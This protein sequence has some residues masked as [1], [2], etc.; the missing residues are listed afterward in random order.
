MAEQGLRRAAFIDRD[1]VINRELH[2][3]HR[4][5]DFHV[6]PG[7]VEGLRMLAA[8]GY[9]LVVVTNQGGIAKGLYTPEQYESLTAHMRQW[10]QA[11][12]VEFDGIYHCPHHPGGTV[13][14]WSVACTC[15]KPEPGMMLQASEEL[16][17]DLADSVMVGDKVS[18]VEAAR[19]AGVGRLV[20]VESGHALPGNTS[21]SAHH[22]CAGLAEAARWA[23]AARHADPSEQTTFMP[24]PAQTP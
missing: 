19:R 10:F 4:V 6:L 20:L 18:D 9:A 3:V 21:G 24:A 16:G 2:H 17:L 22:R 15:R 5:E 1:G 14:Q 11:Q 13:A 12:G 8:G 7:V 23:V